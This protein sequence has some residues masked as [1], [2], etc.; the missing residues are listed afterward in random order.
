MFVA[1][2]EARHFRARVKEKN[3][4]KFWES[5]HKGLES[6]DFK[7]EHVSLRETFE[8]FVEDGREIINSWNPRKVGGFQSGIHLHESNINT[9]TFSNI[10]GQ[11]IYSTFLQAFNSPA[12]IGSSL[13]RTV[14]TSFS[15]EKIAGISMLSDD[16][17]SIQ[18]GSPYPRAGVNE[19][20]VETPQTTKRGIMVEVTKEAIFFDRTGQLLDR[21]S[22]VAETLAMNK[23]KRIIDA[24][25][26]VTSL[27]NRKGRGV[28]ATYGDNSGNHDF[29]N[30]VATN[31]LADFSDIENALLAFEDLTD[32]NTGEPIVLNGYQVLVPG[33][34]VMTARRLLT[35]TTVRQTT[36]T[37]TNTYSA[38]PLPGNFEVLSSPYVKSRSGSSTSWYMG[39]FKQAFAYMEN[40]PIQ[41]VQAPV[42]S[43]AEFERDIVSQF[44]ASERG[45]VACLEPRAVVR[46]TA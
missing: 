28:I 25:V 3:E 21:A 11:I 10:T 46:N 15:G 22:K 14:S 29:D 31:A 43:Q 37:N 40:W 12:L 42:N 19:D 39:D 26:G 41:V 8:H 2:E 20:Y 27:Y 4:H 5:F 38:S 32:P 7:P 33:A 17:D 16:V 23:E 1:K 44:K 36:N 45:T 18:E 9:A 24:A 30:L 6:G 35:A 13:C 34:L